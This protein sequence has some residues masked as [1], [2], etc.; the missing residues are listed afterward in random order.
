MPPSP[1][2]PPPLPPSLLFDNTA[3]TVCVRA[4][5][6]AG[7]AHTRAYC[8]LFIL[9]PASATVCEHTYA[10]TLFCLLSPQARQHARTPPPISAH[11][12]QTHARTHARLPAP[13]PVRPPARTKRATLPA[14]SSGRFYPS[15]RVRGRTAGAHTCGIR[16][17]ARTY[18]RRRRRRT[19]LL[20]GIIYLMFG[21]CDGHVRL[22]VLLPPLCVCARRGCFCCGWGVVGFWGSTR[23]AVRCCSHYSHMYAQRGAVAVGKR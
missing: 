7:P 5:F 2:L 16:T 14:C 17:R 18:I 20:C 19:P 1:S 11:R 12:H 4:V 13:P 22:F 3:D 21:L 10:Y 6:G 8:A 9:L 15:Q 23:C